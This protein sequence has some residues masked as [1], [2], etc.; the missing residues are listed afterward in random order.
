MMRSDN[1]NWYDHGG[2]TEMTAP[3]FNV[4]IKDK[5]G[6]NRIIVQESLS[7]NCST[8]VSE[9]NRNI[10]NVTLL[11][12]HSAN[13]AE[14]TSVELEEKEYKETSV[15]EEVKHYFNI[16][17]CGRN[18]LDRIDVTYEQA[19]MATPQDNDYTRM[20]ENLVKINNRNGETFS[21]EKLQQAVSDVKEET[22]A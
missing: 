9:S 21:N 4:N 22:D 12:K 1:L 11:Q 5:D 19:F 8:D 18:I 3:S 15:T 14:Y 17:E 6:S 7:E 16:F 13:V 2:Y 10:V 20:L